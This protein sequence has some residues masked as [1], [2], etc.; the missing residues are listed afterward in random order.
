MK[1]IFLLAVTCLLVIS[2]L[3]VVSA[4]ADSWRDL[5]DQADSLS[6]AAN[7]DSAIILGRM[8]LEEVQAQFGQSDTT[9]ALV[10]NLLGTNYYLQAEYNEAESLWKQALSI[11]E[12][13][14]GPE[15]PQVADILHNLASLY[16][17]QGRYEE[18]E[19]LHMRALAIREKTFGRDHPE[20]ARSLINLAN[21]YYDQGKYIEAEPLYKRA[22][23]I[24]E[25]AQ[26]PDH[27]LVASGLSNL[28]DLYFEQ[29]KYAQAEPLYKRALA[30]VEKALGPEHPYAAI[31]LN[32]L[33]NLYYEQGKY[34]EAEPLHKRA[35]T[36][37][38]QAL[39]SDHP[40]VAHSLNNL[41]DLYFEQGK[42]AEAEPLYKQALTIREKALGPEHPDVAYS[43]NNLAILYRKQGKYAEAEPLYKRALAIWEKTLGADHPDAAMGMNNLANLYCKQGKYAEADPLYKQ[44]LATFE[45]TLGSNHPKVAWCLES[46]SAYYRLR[47][48]MRRSLEL[49]K[50]AFQIRK[51]NFRDGAAVMSERDA[52]TYS[53]FMRNSAD[54]F[55][56]V[57]FD[58]SSGEDSLDYAA[59]DVMFSTKGQA[60]EAIFARARE[61]IMLEQL[62]TLADSLRYA[63]SMLSKLYVE[64]VGEENPL[65]Y[66]E[67]LDKASRDKERFESQ[68]AQSNVAYRDLQA[69]LDVNAKEIV[70]I[71]NVLPKRSVLIEYMKYN[72][73]SLNPDTSVSRY[74]A[75]ILSGSGEMFVK[76][77]NEAAEID[78]L[79]E[80]Y[81][82]H[83]LSVASSDL[84]P[85]VVDQ[86]DYNKVSRAIY[87]RIW[88]PLENHIP[89]NDLLFVA[90]DG[91]LNMLSFAGLV[92]DEGTYLIEKFT[93]HYLSSGRDLIRLQDEVKPASGLFALGNPDYNAPASARI[94]KPEETP[95]DSVIEPVYYVSRNIRSGSR[96][97][98]DIVVK[99][100]PGT[101]RE[102]EQI[103]ESWQKTS[104]E[105]TRIFLSIDASEEKFK[106]EAPGNRI[107]HLAT[108]G[109]FLEGK[110]QPASSKRGF[111][112]DMSFVGENPLLLSGLFLAG[113]N[114]HGEGAD[115]LGAEDGILTAE[116]VTAM[117]LDGT[118]LV[119]LSACETGLGEVKSGEG[120][121]G[122]RRA[123]QMAGA[124]TV[125]SALWPVSDEATAEMMSK[126][127]ER[128]DA[129]LPERI[130]KLQL[131]TITALRNQN[132]ADHP[133][134]WAAFI[135][136]G[137]WR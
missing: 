91:G 12:K 24:S 48:D 14:F 107:V 104:P 20:V 118:E 106:S 96:E 113:A 16:D 132:E 98:R 44:A 33:A 99:P 127:Y 121:Y 97:L 3:A 116:E 46:L 13:T 75:F 80:Q 64:G 60:S 102:V 73:V 95:K 35:L 109:Y 58:L 39:G 38:K 5:L 32:N 105:S 86:I 65:S 15:H 36:I 93:I 88:E 94:A 112:S 7:Y 117:N 74:L 72:Y 135:A 103:A 129:S 40:N 125:V 83:M 43:L 67:K 84:L 1:I 115:A 136:V 53:Q 119:V 23:A 22:L 28:A 30:I 108:H 11:R 31:I 18:S 34:A 90:P 123:F 10:L 100:L 110:D 56:S 133:F 89:E 54:N 29:G 61:I 51:K 85:S 111:D 63:R 134:S 128:K 114:L 21:L 120:V 59:A 122:L 47:G 137:D 62:G 2:L 69:A 25:Q 27:P 57:Y 79:I 49:A 66:G 68:L 124:R 8:A 76:D 87:E 41:A 81:R 50:R 70:D 82:R 126:L 71:L 9:V 17:D 78:S 26:G 130:R 52:L 131:E 19:S 101:K 45:K 6:N 42:Y 55:L 77:L 37:W 92:D 4:S